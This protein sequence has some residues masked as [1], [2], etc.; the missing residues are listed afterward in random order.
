MNSTTH[1][2]EIYKFNKNMNEDDMCDMCDIDKLIAENN[3]LIAKNKLEIYNKIMEYY[4]NGFND[5][6]YI[7]CK[8]EKVKKS[9]KW[10]PCN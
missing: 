6:Y 1:N 5:E 3:K 7:T 9:F 4:S 8:V 2:I 10:N